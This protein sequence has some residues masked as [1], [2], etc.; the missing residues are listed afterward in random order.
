MIVKRAAHL[1]LIVVFVA[2]CTAMG[3]AQEDPAKK[4]SAFV[5]KWQSE[6]TFANGEKVASSL[7]CRWS[8]QS[9]FLVCEQ[10]IRMSSGDHHQLTIY[11]YNNKDQSYSYTTLGDPGSRPTSGNLQIE[12]NRWIY[13]TTFERDGKT[14]QARTINEFSTAHKESFTVQF[15]EDGGATWKTQLEGTASK[16]GD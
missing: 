10:A 1:F 4:L 6:G 16:V 5:G 11:S 2:A 9:D 3:R 15:S 13:L 12:G 8:S 7:E 14:M